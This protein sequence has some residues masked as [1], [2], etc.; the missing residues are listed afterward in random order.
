MCELDSIYFRVRQVFI[1][2]KHA[3]YA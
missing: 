3:C 1:A 2:F